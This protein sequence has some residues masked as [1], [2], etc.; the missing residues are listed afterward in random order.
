MSIKTCPVC[1]HQQSETIND[2]EQCGWDFPVMLGTGEAVAQDLQAR[3]ARAREEWQANRYNP[4]IEPELERD[5]FETWDEFTAR[6]AARYWCAG[7]VVLDKNNYDIE[8]ARF[9]IA[10][11][12]KPW[13]KKLKWTAKQGC[14]SLNRDE[15]RALFQ[16]GI[17][18]PIYFEL[19]VTQQQAMIQRVL[20][21][22]GE[23]EI[24]V[25]TAQQP[26][27]RQLIGQRGNEER[28]ID[29]QDGTVT[30]TQTGLMWMRPCLGQQWKKGMVA[31]E[32]KAFDWRDAC[33]QRG[34]DFAGYSDWR[35]P[36]FEELKTLVYCS[37]GKRDAFRNDGRGG[38]C[39]GD[40]QQPTIDLD[41][42]PNTPAYW[43]WS[44]L[45][46]V[47]SSFNEWGV[48]FDNGGVSLYGKNFNGHVRL[49]RAG[50]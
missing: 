22:T 7:E 15:A 29:H 38:Q 4:D 39:L 34:D 30:D 28:Y 32:A 19:D 40:Y 42:F 33:K 25:E 50:Q 18:W 35:L 27:A 8:T 12:V 45:L 14:L 26:N 44:P 23:Q 3:L 5:P 41:A 1:G 48:D 9:D 17:H 36:T 31:G 20:L 24:A 43:F 6:I 21:F 10:F 2:C 47:N 37:T 16:K 46:Y 13:V 49:V 11:S